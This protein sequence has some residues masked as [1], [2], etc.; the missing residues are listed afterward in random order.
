MC[1]SKPPVT[2]STRVS[3]YRRFENGYV[4]VV[5]R[6]YGAKKGPIAVQYAPRRTE[7]KWSREGKWS[8]VASWEAEMSRFGGLSLILP[9]QLKSHLPLSAATMAF[10]GSSHSCLAFQGVDVGQ[11]IL[12]DLIWVWGDSY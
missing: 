9:S 3:G 10:W 7:R 6:T 11:L 4:V 2:Y 5:R 1:L 8:A 12:F